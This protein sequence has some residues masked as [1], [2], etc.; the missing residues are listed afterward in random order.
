MFEEYPAWLAQTEVTAI[1]N[2]FIKQLNMQPAEQRSRPMYYRTNQSLLKPLYDPQEHGYDELL[3]NAIEAAEADG[4]IAVEEGKRKPWE[5]RHKNA[6]LR[7]EWRAEW[8]VRVAF[9][10]ISHGGQFVV[11]ST[12]ARRTRI[13]HRVP[14]K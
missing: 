4:V 12:E 2:H 1:L 13:E 5:A 7:F 10:A 14:S 8:R 3:W 6:R 9:Y 11:V